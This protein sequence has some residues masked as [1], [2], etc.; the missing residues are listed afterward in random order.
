MINE[1]VD[2]TLNAT[3]LSES[4][5]NDLNSFIEKAVKG[6]GSNLESV[7][8]FG[9]ARF[10]KDHRDIDLALLVNELPKIEPLSNKD[11]RYKASNSPYCYGRDIEL[12][13]QKTYLYEDRIVND[14]SIIHYL[15]FNPSEVIPNKPGYLKN[16]LKNAGY[17]IMRA[18]LKDSLVLHGS[19]K[20][21]LGL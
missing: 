8:L 17:L 18:M 7:R 12:V 13:Y 10:T 14:D 4:E 16:E 2:Y 15:V 19:K 11:T 6:Y 1:K 9:S 21:E 3:F 20:E 5:R